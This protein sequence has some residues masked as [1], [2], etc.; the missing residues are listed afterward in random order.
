MNCNIEISYWINIGNFCSLYV[1]TNSMQ[2]TWCSGDSLNGLNLWWKPLLKN[3]II[4]REWRE[5]YLHLQVKRMSPSLT[6]SNRRPGFK[7]GSAHVGFCDGQKWR[8]GRFFSPRTSVSPANLH[9][10]SFST[11][12]FTI[13]RGWH[14]R[15]GATAVP[16]ASQTK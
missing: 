16:I 10:I 7:P 2:S 14:N 5:L 6:Y 1:F 12:I 11:I 4:S 9:S 13:T 3:C 15:P 8:W